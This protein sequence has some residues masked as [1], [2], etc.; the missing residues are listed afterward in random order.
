MFKM[1]L[2]VIFFFFEELFLEFAWINFLIGGILIIIK[3]LVDI[4][5]VML[6]IVYRLYTIASC[7]HLYILFN[8]IWTIRILIICIFSSLN[9]I[10]SNFIS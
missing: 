8:C 10:Q 1:F 7:H 6:G 4:G 2:L 5:R 9:L 3:M